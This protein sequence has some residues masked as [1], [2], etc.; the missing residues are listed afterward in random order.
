[1][2]S[3]LCSQ[4]DN[5]NAFVICYYK[6]ISLS[7]D[8]KVLWVFIVEFFTI[9][10]LPWCQWH[11][12]VFVKNNTFSTTLWNITEVKAHSTLDC[13]RVYYNKYY[14]C[15]SES[16]INLP[17]VT[18]LRLKSDQCLHVGKISLLENSKIAVD[19]LNVLL[20]SSDTVYDAFLNC[21]LR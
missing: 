16:Y 21:V 11:F 7:L 1:M 10:Y 15:I 17:P 19:G 18:F 13:Q 20:S 2:F 5:N 4:A 12:G 9:F 8:I 14:S 3:H 6:F